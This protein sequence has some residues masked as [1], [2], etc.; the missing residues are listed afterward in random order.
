MKCQ[1]QLPWPAWGLWQPLVRSCVGSVDACCQKHAFVAQIR[2]CHDRKTEVEVSKELAQQSDVCGYS[3]A[4]AAPVKQ[5]GLHGEDK[6]HCLIGGYLTVGES[7]G[8][9]DCEDS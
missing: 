6:T 4:N 3:E 1:V 8:Q 5:S 7:D 9:S 2:C